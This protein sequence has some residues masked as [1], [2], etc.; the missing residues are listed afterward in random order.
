[1]KHD[2]IA[3]VFSALKNRETMGRRTALVPASSLG[4]AILGIMK[5]KGYVG[6]FQLTSR[7]KHYDVSL[8]GK[9]NDCNAI[10]PRFAVKRD[11]FIKWEKRFLPAN[12]VGILILS[13][14][15]G[16]MDHQR[17][18]QE[19]LGGQLLGFVY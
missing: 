3:D 2:T 15:R 12:D 8:T 1:M 9:I 19:G 4:A 14:S 6:D 17:A 10:R 5:E 16:V 11:E 13:T 7:Q 18:K